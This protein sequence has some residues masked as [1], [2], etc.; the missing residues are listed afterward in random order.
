MWF[1]SRLDHLPV[2]QATASMSR[3]LGG[4]GSCMF[5]VCE[6]AYNT[7]MGLSGISLLGKI[8]FTVNLKK[9]SI[10]VTWW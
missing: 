9:Q 3:K 4:L 6:V 2:K 8:F 7:D 5:N 1:V 10:S